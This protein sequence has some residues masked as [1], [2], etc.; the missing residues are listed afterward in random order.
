MF[1]VNLATVYI[2]N[3][4]LKRLTSNEKIINIGTI[5]YTFTSYR[6][7]DMY[8]RG[9]LGESF[10]FIFLPLVVLGLYEI[11]YGNKKNFYY[12]VIGMTGIIY[13]H[14]ISTLIVGI[15]ILFFI[16]F[17]IKKLFQNKLYLYLTLRS[18]LYS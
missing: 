16:I 10:S 6:M 15:L 17:N 9:C 1:S 12:L 2:V 18:H 7:V 3:F 13:S 5:L 14:V 4:V 11:F 8:A